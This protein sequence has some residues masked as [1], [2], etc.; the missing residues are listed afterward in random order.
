MEQLNI[1][2]H[3]ASVA[4]KDRGIQQAAD[5]KKSLLEFARK[6]AVELARAMGE[7][8]ADDVQRR[9]VEKGISVRALG[10]AAGALFRG[11]QWQWTG[12]FKKSERAHS[13]SNL[14]RIWVW[15]GDK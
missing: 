1:F 15:K 12:R 9:L 7:I 11:G 10:S 13:H 6:E 4:A 2:D 5:H 8:T 14:I 3:A